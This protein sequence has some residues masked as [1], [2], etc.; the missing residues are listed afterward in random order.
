MRRQTVDVSSEA[1]AKTMTVVLL[2][3]GDDVVIRKA[4]LVSRIRSRLLAGRWDRGLA[5][6]ASPDATVEYSLRARHLAAPVRRQTAARAVAREL[7][8]AARRVRHPLTRF[9]PHTV[10]MTPP[11]AEAILDNERELRRLAARLDSPAP[12]DPRGLA[13]CW[14]LVTNGA[15]PLL[16][17]A[18][19]HELR[20]ACREA[21]R[22]L[23]PSLGDG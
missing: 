13:C 12:V 11:R 2:D 6:G 22:L 14:I 18:R 19:S 9:T 20:A 8:E 23:E 1:G 4:G 3:R 7:D 10:V 5:G 16:C 15:G 17:P 21:L